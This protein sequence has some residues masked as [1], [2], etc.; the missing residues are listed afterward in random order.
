M[1]RRIT[2]TQRQLREALLDL[3]HEKPYESI[4][5]QDIADRADTARITFYRHYKEKNELLVDCLEQIYENLQAA[6][7]LP[8]SVLIEEAGSISF[9]ALDYWYGYIAEN[10]ELFKTILS[11]SMS[12]VVRQNMRGFIIQNAVSI[13]QSVEIDLASLLIPIDIFAAYIAEAQLGLITW[14]L[15]T[16]S[17]YPPS[18][19]AEIVVRLIETGAFGLMNKPV[20]PGDMSFTPF[21]MPTSSDG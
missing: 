8:D 1:D 16:D 9:K 7:V 11:D 4:T 13:M 21:V 20:E 5:I 17:D 18:L 6:F 3:I 10:R 15:E 14:W 2:R 19:L 12:A